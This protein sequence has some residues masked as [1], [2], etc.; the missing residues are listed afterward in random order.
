MPTIERHRLIVTAITRRRWRRPGTR[1]SSAAVP[2]REQRDAVELRG[3][4]I[5]RSRLQS[6]V[7]LGLDRV[8]VGPLRA[9][10]S[11]TGRPAHGRV[12][13]SRGPGSA[14]PSAVCTS[15]TP[16][17]A[18]RWAWPRPLTW[19]VSYWLMARPAASSAALLMRRPEDRRCIDFDSAFPV[20]TRLRWASR[21]DVGVDHRTLL[22]SLMAVV[23][24]SRPTPCRPF[25]SW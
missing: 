21:L 11:G 16:S 6:C 24:V 13:A 12:G 9:C 3:V 17:C 5:G 19:P 4:P 10:R 25:C 1:W 22:I 23:F 20:L 8:L 7:D 18:L 14:V 2:P 15:E